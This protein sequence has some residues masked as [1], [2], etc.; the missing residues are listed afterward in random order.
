MNQLIQIQYNSLKM[1]SKRIRKHYY[2]TLG[3]RVINSSPSFLA[4][5]NQWVG[6]KA[7]LLIIEIAVNHW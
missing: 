2:K 7:I 4:V 1:L 3:A 6:N 5:S